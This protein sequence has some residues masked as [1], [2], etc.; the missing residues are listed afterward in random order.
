MADIF[1]GEI[2]TFAFGRVPSGWAPCQGQ[3]LSIS[4]HAALFSLIGTTYGGDGRSTFALP[5]LRG[6][7]AIAPGVTAAGSSYALGDHGGEEAHRLTE[8]ELPNRHRVY[9]TP[10]DY[11]PARAAARN[12]HAGHDGAGVAAPVRD[13]PHSVMQPYLALNTCI[14]LFGEFPRE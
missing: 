7:V 6:R 11:T 5:D 3:L 2:R 4:Q 13:R 8:E 10:V 1:L 9:A 12:G 14:A